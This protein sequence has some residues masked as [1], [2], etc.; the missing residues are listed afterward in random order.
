MVG[1]DYRASPDW[2]AL[3]GYSPGSLADAN[4]RSIALL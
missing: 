3:R 1:L 4:L 2:G